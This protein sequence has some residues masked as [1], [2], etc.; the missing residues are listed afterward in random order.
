VT[1]VDDPLDRVRDRLRTPDSCGVPHVD[2]V[3]ADALRPGKLLRPRLV[4]RSALAAGAD[5]GAE[6]VQRAAVEAA[7]AMELLHVAT[8]VHDDIIDGAVLRRGR[9]S[10]VSRA[11]VATAIVVG[12]LLLARASAAAAATSPAVPTVWA[13]ALDRMAAGQLREAGLVETPT[14]GAQAEYASLKTAE[15][16]RSC[17]ETGAI[18]AGATPEVVLAH[19]LFGLHF[20]RAF[21]HVDDLLDLHGD[22]NRTGKQPGTDARNGIPTAL[23]LLPGPRALDDVLE[24]VAAELDRARSS[25][26][27]DP[28]SAALGAWGVSALGRA[29]HAALDRADDDVPAK[30]AAVFE[31]LEPTPHPR[32]EAHACHDSLPA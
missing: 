22:P 12:D 24:V 10:V 19:G 29:A 3:V 25:L 27:P 14:L 5:L 32:P 17:A 30:V 7:V 8:L 16:F 13:R 2:A 23:S 28:R 20:G 26:P 18:V 31:R 11:G 21:Q 6:D 9:P 15:L 1:D 4:L